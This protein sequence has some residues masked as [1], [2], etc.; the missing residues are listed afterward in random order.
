MNPLGLGSSIDSRSSEDELDSDDSD[1]RDLSPVS[2]KGLMVLLNVDG[3]VVVVRGYR[4]V[5]CSWF[6]L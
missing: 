6:N 2:W 3:V 1:S 5:V 4:Y